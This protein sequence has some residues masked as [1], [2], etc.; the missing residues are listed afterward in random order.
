MCQFRFK[1]RTNGFENRTNGSRTDP[2]VSLRTR[3]SLV[4]VEI[5]TFYV[6]VIDT[7]RLLTKTWAC[8]ELAFDYMALSLDFLPLL[9]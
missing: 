9:Y 3:T 8:L 7:F 6:S 2:I 4:S 5:V 1:P